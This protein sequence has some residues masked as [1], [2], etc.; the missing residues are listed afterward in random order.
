MISLLF[1]ISIILL[2]CSASC[3]AR[4]MTLVSDSLVFDDYLKRVDATG[5]VRLMIDDATITGDHLMFYVD[6]NVVISSGNVFIKRHNDEIKSSSLVINLTEK[7]LHLYDLN[8]AII[9]FDKKG[10]IYVSIKQLIDSQTQKYGHFARFTSCD[11]IKPHYYLSTWRFLYYPDKSIHMF[12][13]QFYNKLS[14]FPFN[15]VP[16][17]VP[18]IEWIPIPYYY[19]QLGKRNMVLNFPT[20]GEKKNSGW[21]LFVQNKLDYRYHNDKESSL[22]LDW[23]QAKKNR[24]GE[25]GYG[26]H[27][28][29]G[30]TN[31]NGDI[32]L[33]NYDY[34]VDNEKKKNLTY[35]INQ[36]ISYKDTAI[37][38]SYHLTDV[39]ER[40]N[41]TGSSHTLTKSLLIKH[42]P[43][44]FPLL[45][46]YKEN[47]NYTNKFQ[48]QDFVFKKDFLHQNVSFSVTKKKYSS[49]NRY[50]TLAKLSHAIQLPYHIKIKQ[51]FNFDQYEYRNSTNLPEQ[52]LNYI[53]SLSTVLPHNINMSIYINYLHDL[54]QDTVTSDIK[55]GVN[56]YLYKL[57]EIKFSQNQTFFKSK[58]RY[59]FQTQSIFSLGNYREVRYFEDDPNYALPERFDQLE[60]NMYFFSQKVSK[61]I[62]SLPASSKLTL[63]S[64]YKQYIF[65]NENKSLFEGDAQYSLNY[66]IALNSKFLSFIKHST[67]YTRQHGHKDNNSPFYSFRKSIAES[68]RLSKKITFYYH[69]KRSIKLPFSFDLNWDHSAAYNWLLRSTPYS[70]YVSK[71]TMSLNKKYK[72]SAQ[73]S[74]NLN[75]AWK[76]ESN[77]FTP[78][79]IN[80]SGKTKEK[81]NFNYSLNFNMNDLVFDHTYIVKQSDFNFNFPVGQNPDFQWKIKGYFKY[82]KLNKAFQLAGYQ[83]QKFSIIKDEHERQIEIG[84]NKTI[85]ELF[86]KFHF[87]MFSKDPLI[88]RKTNNVI[89]FEGRLNK[90]SQERF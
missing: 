44:I 67:S 72:L 51:N 61:S 62:M 65:K 3:L 80:L 77:L 76:K 78:L 16:F 81:F 53:S 56:N 74:K 11:A 59:T 25:W 32:Y 50:T 8:I 66:N 88:L 27:H 39:A 30:N 19:Y 60:P 37:S 90:Q 33:Y 18:L 87:K 55:S 10:K 45:S 31:F 40:I 9:P 82:I 7:K 4:S 42:S 1:R 54:D 43:K 46:S 24:S 57:P 73:S 48:S 63:S 12:G 15:I 28:Y 83:F 75:K 6:D 23:Y 34:Q 5:N 20:I 35:K 29:Y 84:Y 86:F 13:V 71:I 22:F 85:K 17:P 69:K 68:N 36:F 2:L 38:G 14:F 58:Q 64:T 89:K 41:S 47:N 79:I 21:G 49:T 52:T 26:I 70:N